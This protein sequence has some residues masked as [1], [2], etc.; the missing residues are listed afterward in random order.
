M[1]CRRPDAPWVATLNDKDR[2][3]FELAAATEVR[4]DQLIAAL[5]RRNEALR[6]AKD[7]S[8]EQQRMNVSSNSWTRNMTPA[9]G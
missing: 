4:E 5:N 7:R 9:I 6:V 3:L 2:A 1:G 8:G